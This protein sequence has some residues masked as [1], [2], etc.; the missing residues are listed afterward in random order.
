MAQVSACIIQKL[1]R[2]TYM[3]MFETRAI[4]KNCARC[5]YDGC[6]Q[7]NDRQRVRKFHAAASNPKP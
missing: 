4:N 5:N 6:K 1:R 7:T 3:L 2:F